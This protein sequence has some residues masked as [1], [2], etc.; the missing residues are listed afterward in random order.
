MFAVFKS[1]QDSRDQVVIK[2]ILG[3]IVEDPYD[4]SYIDMTHLQPNLLE[5]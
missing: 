2:F 3:K 5:N 1:S 4:I